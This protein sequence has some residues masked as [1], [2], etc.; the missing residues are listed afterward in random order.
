MSA[1]RLRLARLQSCLLAVV[2]F[3]YMRP[4]SYEFIQRRAMSKE[5]KHRLEAGA[6][7]RDHDL[8]RANNRRELLGVDRFR[9]LEDDRHRRRVAW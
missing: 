6:A 9:A 7:G 2:F 5:Y 8:G 3:I 1:G 4:V